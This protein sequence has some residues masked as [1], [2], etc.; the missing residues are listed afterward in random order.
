MKLNVKV[1][2]RALVCAGTLAAATLLASCG[3]GQQVTTG[4]PNRVIAF[5]D[6]MSVITSTGYK[7][8]VNALLSNSSTAVDCASN[9]LWIQSLA[10][11]YNLVFPQCNST[12]T[13]DPVSRIWATAGATVAD[14]DTQITE[15]LNQGGFTSNDLVTVLVGANDVVQQFGTYPAT[16]EAQITANLTT[17]AKMLAAQ[18]NR[19]AGY[20]A[21]V[22][23][24]TIPQ[25]GLTPF[26]GDRSADSTDT[27]PALLTRLSNAFND[28]LL[29]NLLNNGHEIGLVQLDE[30]LQAVD[31]ATQTGQSN[32]SYANTTL[33]ACTVAL[34][35]CTTNTL[36]ANAVSSNY[37]WADNRHF[38]V[39]GQAAL[40][41]LALTRATNNPF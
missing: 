9:P 8:S 20:G 21:K 16:S 38:G 3:G 26:G 2:A 28:T 33:P 15:Q 6:E 35:K 1:F 25:M 23:I 36:V 41:S 24:V 10:N 14:L 22:L 27:N 7:Y 12:L 39:S 34:P 29:A 40:G 31:T 19:L 32:A 4:R 30:Y 18:V 17:S 37:L 5:G 11:A 13:P